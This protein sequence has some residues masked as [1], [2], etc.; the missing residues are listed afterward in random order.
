MNE[1]PICGVDDC[2]EPSVVEFYDEQSASVRRARC[3]SHASAK[4][5][6]MS[7]L[8]SMGEKMFPI[9]GQELSHAIEKLQISRN[10]HAAI[11]TPDQAAALLAYIAR[12]ELER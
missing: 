12:S 5:R 3:R 11:L 2:E 6:S 4:L 8:A 9:D 7:T 10:G 1:Q